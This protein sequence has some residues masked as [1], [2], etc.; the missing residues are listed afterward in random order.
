MGLTGRPNNPL[1]LKVLNG[2]GN[3]RDSGGRPIKKGPDFA[4]EAPSMPSWL[5]GEA[6]NTWKRTVPEL[7]RRGL[8]KRVDRD[9]L[10]AYCVAVQTM[11]DAY[12]LI[13]DEGL[14]I[15]Q[16]TGSRK[17]HPAFQ[18][19]AQS[20]N[21]IRAFAHEFGLTPASEANIVRG[22][23]DG[24]QEGNPFAAASG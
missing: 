9:A 13:A 16:G 12:R 15:E 11:R 19:L 10:V 2:R 23:E 21:T 4:R 6:R 5:E 7:A 20:Q 17:P 1:G 24:G 8:L 18:I 14:T 22:D 3:G